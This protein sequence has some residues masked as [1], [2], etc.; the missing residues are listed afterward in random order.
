MKP[1]LLILAAGMGSRYGGLKQLDEV[2]QAGE[3]IMDYSIYDA[4]KAGFGKVVFVIRRDFEQEFK[5]KIGSR[6]EGKI[7]VDYA[8]QGPDTYVPSVAGQVERAKPWGTGHAV[9]VAK[10]VVKEPFVAINADDFYGYAG[11]EKMAKFLSNDCKPT[12]YAMVGYV[13]N[14]T[15][16]ENG[17]VSRGVCSMDENNLLRT[18]T[19]CTGIE[20]TAEGIFYN[21]ENGKTPLDGKSLVSMNIWGFHPHIFELLH[22]GFNEFVEKNATN[23]KAEFYISSYANDL[24]NSGTATFEVLPNDEKWYGVTYREDKEM[25]QAAFAE[26][27]G[28]GVYPVGLWK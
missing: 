22:E 27:T 21:G 12:N 23:P 13:L 2:G 26:M 20:E 7:A 5:D 10:D 4:L 17:A 16:S 11:F 14:N 15:L 18:V 9:L 24:I 3:A 19:E 6:W 1:T 25:V 28:R 8:F